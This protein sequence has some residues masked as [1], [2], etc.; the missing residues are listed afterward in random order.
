VSVGERPAAGNHIALRAIAN[1]FEL[2]PR[3]DQFQITH[4]LAVRIQQ[5]AAAVVNGFEGE[6]RHGGC[7]QSGEID[8]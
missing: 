7:A 5:L 1:G 8:V 6:G 2:P 4:M 3:V